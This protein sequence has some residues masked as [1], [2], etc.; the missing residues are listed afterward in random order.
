MNPYTII[1]AITVSAIFYAG[2]VSLFAW[3][4]APL[5]GA[6]ALVYGSML[7]LMMTMQRRASVNCGQERRQR[8]YQ[9]QRLSRKA[10]SVPSVN[11]KSS[12]RSS[13]VRPVSIS[14]YSRKIPIP[15]FYAITQATANDDSFYD[16]DIIVNASSGNHWWLR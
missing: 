14:G 6:M 1:G 2:M 5:I 13:N 10:I 16:S 8:L 9:S 12:V 7:L 11:I 3:M 4:G 15:D